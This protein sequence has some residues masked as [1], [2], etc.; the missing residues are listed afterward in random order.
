M[1][2]QSCDNYRLHKNMGP[3]FEAGTLRFFNLGRFS[4]IRN[5]SNETYNFINIM[6]D[7]NSPVSVHKPHH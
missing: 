4:R 1:T 5:D 7:P 3:V 2:I 6:D